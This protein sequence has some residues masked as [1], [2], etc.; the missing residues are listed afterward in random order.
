MGRLRGKQLDGRN[1]DLTCRWFTQAY[2]EQWETWRAYADQWLHAQDS[3]LSHRR[4]A[5]ILFLES[6]LVGKGLEPDPA[7]LFKPNPAL[8]ELMTC[9]EKTYQSMNKSIRHNSIVE[10]IDWVITKGFSV[11]NGN[12]VMVPLVS[13]P[14]DKVKVQSNNIETVWLWTS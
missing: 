12:G 2:G 10:F 9:V 1:S 13:N 8:P 14:F 11:S 3:G 6:Y 7:A 5:I 4:D